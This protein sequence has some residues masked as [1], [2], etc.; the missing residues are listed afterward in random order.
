MIG[1]ASGGQVSIGGTYLVCLYLLI[2]IIYL[3]NSLGQLFLLNILLGH[4]NFH[5]YGI[6]IMQNI[7]QG[8]YRAVVVH[9]KH[10]KAV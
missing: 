2:K 6:E 8:K 5:L 1:G 4:K 10:K 9:K 7:L 3:T